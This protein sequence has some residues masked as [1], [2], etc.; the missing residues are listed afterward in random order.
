MEGSYD[1]FL[2]YRRDGGIKDAM[3][4][5]QALEERG[6]RV[7]IDLRGMT[8]GLFDVQL[9]QHIDE[10]RDFIVVL[11]PHALDR[12]DSQEDWVRREVERAHAGG[13]NI[14]PVMLNGFSFPDRIP[15][16][17]EFLRHTHGVV[18]SFE[19]YDAFIDKL[20]QYL[21]SEPVRETPAE[22]SSESEPVQTK[23]TFLPKWLILLVFLL[24]LLAAGIR[25]ILS[26]SS[27]PSPPPPAE[28]QAAGTATPESETA[29]D[30]VVLDAQGDW[31]YNNGEYEKALEAHLQAAEVGSKQ[32]YNR[33]GYMYD[34][35]Q[36]TEVDSDKAEHY[37]LL[38]AEQGD[39]YAQ[40]N[41]GTM[42]AQ[43]PLKADPDKAE[44]WYLLAAGQGH[45]GAQNNLGFMY[46]DT[47]NGK[48]D[49]DQAEH[50]FLLSAEQGNSVAQYNLGYIY[51]NDQYGKKDIR[52]AIDW[53]TKAAE[54]GHVGAME[55]LGD[56]NS[57][58]KGVNPK[59]EQAISSPAP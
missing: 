19:Y 33:I 7:Y 45:A 57:A 39:V 16:S 41:L 12:C 13:K 38:A 9:Y 34:L 47:A 11:S 58:G 20:V 29:K 35:G 31:Y 46:L 14:I 3:L 24:L 43:N 52:K 10:C 37:Y 54:Q 23:P 44:S 22:I 50:Y 26:A 48:A 4:L 1:I 59:T 51:Q 17:L 25:G 49:F 36:G 18:P 8:S 30:P 2:S 32:F 5:H 53:Y 55:A 15:S 40:Y 56:I 28:T 42:Y 21:K 6:Y 27:P